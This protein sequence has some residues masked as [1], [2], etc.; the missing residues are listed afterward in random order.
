MMCV[1]VYVCVCVC[2]HIIW[3]VCVLYV[4]CSVKQ[5]RDLHALGY[6]QKFCVV[7]R[8]QHLTMQCGGT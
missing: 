2:E 6:N 3:F 7:F 4:G 5:A 8:T 1:Y